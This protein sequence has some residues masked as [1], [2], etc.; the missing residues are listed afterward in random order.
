[1]IIFKML[2]L[3]PDSVKTGFPPYCLSEWV[4][5]FFM[6]NTLLILDCVK[7]NILIHKLD[8]FVFQIFFLHSDEGEYDDCENQV[9]EEKL[10]HNDHGHNIYHSYRW[11][12]HI[13]EI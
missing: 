6:K 12:V 3:L 5:P 8:D 13:H 11:D 10:T 1:M 7:L 2:W 9:H 4:L